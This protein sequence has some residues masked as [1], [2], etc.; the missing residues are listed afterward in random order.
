M[1]S[2][3]SFVSKHSKSKSSVMHFRMP[4][5]F[6]SGNSSSASLDTHSKLASQLEPPVPAPAPPVRTLV[7]DIIAQTHDVPAHKHE[8][9]S[10]AHQIYRDQAGHGPK[11]TVPQT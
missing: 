2:T 11:A 4:G 3:P 1:P 8:K 7:A 6:R 9:Q 10:E 5:F